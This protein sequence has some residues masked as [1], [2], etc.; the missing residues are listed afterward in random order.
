MNKEKSI[1][2]L[3]LNT[4]SA[5]GGIEKVCRIAGKAIWNICEINKWKFIIFS[6]HDLNIN[7]K[8]NKYFPSTIF[9]G[10]GSR[11]FYFILTSI[12]EKKCKN[13]IVILSH[14]NLLLVGFLIK[15]LSPKTHLIMYVHGIEVWGKLTFMKKFMIKKCNKIIA[16]SQFTKEKMSELNPDIEPSK[17]I[18]IHNCLDPFLIVDKNP[19]KDN[20][21][22]K[23]YGI[24]IKSKILLAV[25]RYSFEEKYKGYDQVIKAIGELKKTGEGNLFYLLVGKYDAHEKSRIDILIKENDLVGNVIFTGFIPDSELT[26][27]FNLADI[28]AMP[29][30]MEGFGIVFIEAAYHGLPVIA[31]NR[32]GSVEALLAGKLGILIDPFNI[33]DIKEAILNIII[34][35][36]HHL[37]DKALLADHFGFENYQRKLSE[38][39]IF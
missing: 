4:F 23:K 30:L 21:L 22:L 8:E 31:G 5:T 10:F 7:A 28:F 1:L 15:F 14:I 26:K 36:P 24:D 16:V 9:R 27:H 38:T 6:L 39:L 32:D 17:I 34:K 18:V 33:N 2:F 12:F 3:N 29:S 25:T 13:N 20:N 37:P 35:T 19:E 11:I